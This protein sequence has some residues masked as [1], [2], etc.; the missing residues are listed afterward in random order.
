[1]GAYDY[2]TK[3]FRTDQIVLTVKKALENR[4]LKKRSC[5]R[6]A[7]SRYHFHRLIGKSPSKRYTISSKGSVKAQTTSSSPEKVGQGRTSVRK[8]DPLLR[9]QKGDTRCIKCAAIRKHC[10]KLNCSEGGISPIR[11]QQSCFEATAGSNFLAYRDATGA[12]G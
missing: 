6:N 11:K 7:E 1:M 5:G 4:L 10:S 2:I 8:G 9:L 3:P 12:P